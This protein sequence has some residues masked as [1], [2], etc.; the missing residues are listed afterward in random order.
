M[1]RAFLRRIFIVAL[2]FILSALYMPRLSA[3][4][5]PSETSD[6]IDMVVGDIETV[7][8]N[9]L[10]RVSVTDPEVVDISD[11]KIDKVSIMA[12]KAGKT[13]LFLWDAGGKRSIKVRVV[14]EDLSAVKAR[15]QKI[16]NE[17]NITGVSLEENLNEGKVVVS[18]AIPKEEKDRL[19]NILSRYSDNLLIL[20]KAEKNEE[21]VQV[22]MQVIEIST[23]L[24]KNLG[25]IWGSQSGNSTKGSSSGS[26]SSSGSGSSTSNSGNINL[27]YNEALP[28][29]NGKIEDFFKIGN[30]SPSANSQNSLNS[31]VGG[32][33][34]VWSPSITDL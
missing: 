15:V 17:A 34:N 6:V 1:K 7:P 20:L 22:D 2:A 12:K 32:C 5:N 18:G 28:P 31:S 19:G 9:S 11:A 8:T 10:T 33:E 24:E 4:E 30:F 23:T 14:N 27:N 26:S 13:I 3:D 29:S 25:I 21:L 16:L